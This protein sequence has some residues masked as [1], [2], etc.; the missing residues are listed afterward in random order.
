[1][2]RHIV[3]ILCFATL[4]IAL[5]TSGTAQPDIKLSPDEP[6]TRAMPIDARIQAA[7]VIGETR[8]VAWGTGMM[9][10]NGRLVPAL[11][12]QTS[13]NGAAVSP[14]RFAHGPKAR[15]YRFV[16]VVT[17]TASFLVVWS[18]RRHNAP[19][20][21]ARR[22]DTSGAALGDEER[23][24]NGTIAPAGEMPF[25][26]YGDPLRGQVLAWSDDGDST[27]GMYAA[28]INADG[29]FSSG[30]RFLGRHFNFTDRSTP[31]PM[32][33]LSVDQR[34][35]V[36]HDNGTIDNREI[37]LANVTG[38][39][40]TMGFQSAASTSAID[41]SL[42]LAALIGQS[43]FFFH[44]ATDTS[45]FATVPCPIGYGYPSFLVKLGEGRYRFFWA[46]I[47]RIDDDYHCSLHYVDV[48]TLGWR[49]RVDTDSVTCAR[50]RAP[51]SPTGTRY[52]YISRGQWNITR[53][54]GNSFTAE[55]KFQRKY[56]SAS[57]G[58]FSDELTYSFGINSAG[59]VVNTDAARNGAC[60][61]KSPPIVLRLRSDSMSVVTVIY[62]AD[63][64]ATPIPLGRAFQHQ[65][66][67]SVGYSDRDAV[68]TWINDGDSKLIGGKSLA[69]DSVWTIAESDTITYHP[70]LSSTRS[71]ATRLEE[72]YQP[73]GGYASYYHTYRGSTHGPIHLLQL[74]ET[75][76]YGLCYL[77]GSCYDPNTGLITVVLDRYY[78][79]QLSQRIFA[80]DSACTFHYNDTTRRPLV[81]AGHAIIPLNNRALLV[82]DSTSAVRI[83][84]N[85]STGLISFTRNGVELTYRR[86]LGPRFLR[87]YYSDS[88][89]TR[90]IMEMY[91]LDGDLQT[92]RQ[93][94]FS[95]PRRDPYIIQ[96]PSDS[97]ILLL[98][99]ADGVHAAVFDRNLNPMIMDAII[100]ATHGD[101]RH[102]AAA[103]DGD[104]LFVVW[105]D[106]RGEVGDIFGRKVNRKAAVGA[107]VE[108]EPISQSDLVL[109]PNPASRSTLL[110]LTG[111]AESPIDVTIFDID[112]REARNVTIDPARRG[113]AMIDLGGLPSGVYIVRARSASGGVWE[114]ML[115]VE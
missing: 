47:D 94:D 48:D 14:T 112:G 51:G 26:T 24:G 101:V 54:C 36:I 113:E 50:A 30:A 4:F 65:L 25:R 20:V 90:L 7:G 55:I 13:R 66:R 35:F 103:F 45:P 60:L 63:T 18:D 43:I 73:G 8:L 33:M 88:S 3:R 29:R 80:F 89:R 12:I 21:Y 83:D 98:T 22:F 9:T 42:G 91:D 99:A 2:L 27:A 75:P 111:T 31:D 81:L 108:T 38:G 41:T 32:L 49:N 62:S 67:P 5:T 79:E 59:E 15:P 68:V 87:T 11:V 19:G 53:Y 105:E 1:M 78:G 95:A 40:G 17:A 82:A 52:S 100:S 69:T 115:V 44:T 114:R 97:T 110:R 72:A 64:L 85:D 86:M 106:Y 28:S 109:Y 84:G 16:T 107:P 34:V 70:E 92:R 77:R 93:L 56:G 61:Q 46:N 37:P 71:F 58:D 96:S 6:F 102:P 57:Y 76:R 74:I 23:I 39:M 104:S 10:P